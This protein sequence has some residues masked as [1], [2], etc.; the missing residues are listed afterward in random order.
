MK[1]VVFFILFLM[2]FCYQIFSLENHLKIRSQFGYYKTVENIKFHLN[3]NK[4]SILKKIEYHLNA[5]NEK[6]KVLYLTIIL[7]SRKP[8]E[9]KFLRFNPH[10][11][12][13]FPFKILIWKDKQN[14]VWVSYK[15]FNSLLQYGVPEKTIKYLNL[16]LKK[17]I[18]KSTKK[19]KQL[20]KIKKIKRAK[21][22][23]RN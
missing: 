8:L 7:Y 9:K 17:I 10:T 12:F 6:N 20:K 2:L 19:I 23:E 15:K 22:L 1:K 18:A 14:N 3:K 21:K 16:N 4:F 11:A 5:E 13:E